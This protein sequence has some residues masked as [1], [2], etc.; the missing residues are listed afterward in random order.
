MPPVTNDRS[1][2]ATAAL[3]LGILAV[4]FAFIPVIGLIAFILAPLAIIF[5]VLG[6]KS[7]KKGQATAGAITGGVG[8]VISIIWL[9]LFSAFVSEV[10]KEMDQVNKDLQT[11]SQ[12]IENAGGNLDKMAKC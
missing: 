3:V 10:D 5:G 11:Y 12:C 7:S 2:M 1:G 6:R 8:L 9:A 4:V